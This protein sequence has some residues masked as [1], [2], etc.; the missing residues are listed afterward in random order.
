MNTADFIEQYNASIQKQSVTVEDD[1]DD[2]SFMDVFGDTE[3]VEEEK[4]VTT[5]DFSFYDDLIEEEPVVSEKKDTEIV[6]VFT[7][8]LQSVQVEVSTAN[9]VTEG[10]EGMFFQ[11][12]L[13]DDYEIYSNDVISTFSKAFN[14]NVNTKEEALQKYLH[15]YYGI[16]LEISDIREIEH[17][18]S[19]QLI[20]LS[21]FQ[22]RNTDVGEIVSIHRYMNEEWFDPV[23]LKKFSLESKDTNLLITLM[24]QSRISSAEL[25][26]YSKDADVLNAYLNLVHKRRFYKETFDI[27]IR[28]KNNLDCYMELSE[29]GFSEDML[30]LIHR[31]DF[32][33]FYRDEGFQHLT[34]E[35]IAFL[36]NVNTAYLFEV[37]KARCAG[38]CHLSFIEQYLKEKNKIND[39]IAK[40]YMSGELTIGLLKN[41]RGNYYL[42]K[43]I[44]DMRKYQLDTERVKPLIA[45]PALLQNLIVFLKFIL[46]KYY[47]GEITFNDYRMY[48]ALLSL[49]QNDKLVENVIKNMINVGKVKS[50]NAFWFSSFLRRIGVPKIDLAK[51]IGS[52][53]LIH[54]ADTGKDIYYS[55][56]DMICRVHAV[57][58]K[59]D[60]V[61][62]Q[63]YGLAVTANGII[64]CP[65]GTLETVDYDVMQQY[66]MAR[67]S[68]ENYMLSADCC[69][70]NKHSELPDVSRILESNLVNELQQIDVVEENIKKL[71][72]N[73]PGYLDYDKIINIVCARFSAY[74]GI[75]R[76][77]YIIIC[78]QIM[79]HIIFM[80]HE[81]YMQ[82][83]FLHM[84]LSTLFS[85][86]YR[87]GFSTNNYQ[88]INMSTSVIIETVGIVGFSHNRIGEIITNLD[89]YVN[90]LTQYENIT[91]ELVA[92]DTIRV[93]G[94]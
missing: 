45:E 33:E 15:I 71:L 12:L 87:Q 75:L 40:D 62:G 86:R 18:A 27:V 1:F 76:S 2:F 10:L 9:K 88:F 83:N 54:T 42:T 79:K 31:D 14:I 78:L 46:D 36:K 59:V 47:L 26:E 19:K 30:F 38:V 63:D 72:L 74:K 53:L 48:L 55:T 28:D 81:G 21:K 7:Q 69:R 41:F 52:V 61:L 66:A 80:K 90:G 82:I 85:K 64:L 58:S 5:D 16:Q 25:L 43:C 50:F 77:N 70:S 11:D 22:Y 89:S 73:L 91:V 84:L 6:P 94:Y 13:E 4:T 65:S 24:L 39:F 32:Y 60:E 92:N 56:Q 23:I 8:H 67:T 29:T 20:E 37:Y 44:V 17:I 57:M 35:D 34:E 51:G 68:L 93:R 49:P 3:I